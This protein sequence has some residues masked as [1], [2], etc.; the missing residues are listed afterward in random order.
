MISHDKRTGDIGEMSLVAELLRH[1]NILVSKPIGDNCP[2][3]LIIDVN[4]KM[5]KT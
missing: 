2:Y 1:R 3:D 5:Y 4:G